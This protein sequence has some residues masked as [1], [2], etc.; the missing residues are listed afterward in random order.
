ML[1]DITETDIIAAAKFG[2]DN[3]K[4]DPLYSPLLNSP[5]GEKTLLKLFQKSV[6][7]CVRYG[8]AKKVER[9][10]KIIAFLLAFNYYKMK[11]CHK[12]EFDHFFHSTT[13]S[14]HKMDFSTVQNSLEQCM[15]HSKDYI[16]LLA[17]AVEPES[18][19]QHIATDMIRSIITAYDHFGIIADLINESSKN[20]YHRL[21]FEIIE[22]NP[23]GYT[24]VKKHA[25]KQ[26]DYGSYP[27]LVLP[28]DYEPHCLSKLNYKKTKCAGI[29]SLNKLPF[30]VPQ[31]DCIAD[32]KLYSDVS[33]D[34]LLKF[35]REI[36]LANCI[37]KTVTVDNEAAVCYL[38]SDYNLYHELDLAQ[39]I[40]SFKDAIYTEK[41]TE[42]ALVPDIITSIPIQYKD[43]SIIDA[44]HF[45]K[46]NRSALH[47][48]EALNFR[49]EYDSGV[50][51]VKT[52]EGF[53][54]RLQRFF[55]GTIDISILNEKYLDF[56]GA[57]ADTTCGDTYRA[58]IFVSIDK[59]SSI[60]VFHIACMSCGLILTQ[61]LDSVSRNQLNII[62]GDQSINLYDY[63]ANKFAIEKIGAAKNFI[64]IFKNRKDVNNSLLASILFSE[65]YYEN[66]ESLGFVTDEEVSQKLK[67]MHG[68]SQYGYAAAYSFDDLIVQLSDTICSNI[69]NRIITESITLYLMELTIMEESAIAFANKHIVEF[70]AQI[71]QKSSTQILRN[72]GEIMR[73]YAKTI[74]FWNI[75]LNY[76]S[77]QKSADELRKAFRIDNQLAIYTRNQT[78]LKEVYES[79]NNY[80][81][82]IE[83]YILSAAG[84]ILTVISIIDFAVDPKNHIPLAAAALIVALLL[85]LKSR[86]FKAKKNKR[87]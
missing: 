20:I 60:G 39:N 78:M 8:I 54:D 7:I 79:K 69:E 13:C 45:E 61:Y 22:S 87:K 85:F 65:S 67:K 77:S 32:V 47:I 17:I 42:W 52:R 21:G 59:Q 84:A 72:Y 76:T 35:Q 71:D 44:A 50:P 81:N 49:T 31:P 2:Y 18:R 14:N 70:L 66:G 63:I 25:L 4:N 5:N 30:F 62:D 64:T 36:T 23:C 9:G 10:G 37:E 33:F 41:S 46:Y 57:V 28:I 73:E 12:N 43:I 58:S 34:D 15:A 27:K 26:V 80:V 56:Q 19:N 68:F 24:I 53:K 29:K 16:Y 51:L 38:V 74:D 75:Q 3:F 55:L 6:E 40:H 82:Q 11:I 86:L 1:K 83:S 48:L